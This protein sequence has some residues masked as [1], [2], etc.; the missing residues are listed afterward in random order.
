MLA[1]YLER[2]GLPD[3]A[4]RPFDEA[5]LRALAAAH[6]ARIPFENTRAHRGERISVLIDD[7]LD[8][9]V[10]RAEG[11]V[12]YA[13]NGGLAWLLEALGAGVELNAAQVLP[14]SPGEPG[15]L[16]MSHLALIVTLPG[17]GR[18][19]L[20]DVGFGGETIIRG[21][22]EDGERVATDRG[23]AYRIDRRSRQLEDFEGLAW[24]HSTSPGSRFMRSVIV[25]STR[26]DGIATLF[27]RDDG[28]TIGWY[29]RGVADAE[30]RTVDAAE[31]QELASEVFGL[32]Q[33]LPARIMR[34]APAG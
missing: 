20:V 19:F 34:Y 17:D 6:A 33:P 7:I 18:A 24:W 31:A 16:P 22:P 2:I 32:R 1:A 11:G 14:A 12:C 8:R 13:L 9:I 25:S 21:V 23:S 10:A 3:A 4:S 28:E 30:A 15:G 5:G 29:Y 26:A 27:G